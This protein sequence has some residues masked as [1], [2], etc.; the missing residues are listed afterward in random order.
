MAYVYYF[1]KGTLEQK[2]KI[3][4]QHMKEALRN[5]GGIYLK[6]GQLIATIDV[7]VPDQYRDTMMDLTRC[8]PTST[9]SN[10]KK[11]VEGETGKPLKQTFQEFDEKPISS[12]SIAQ[13]HRAR[14]TSGQEV[15]VKV[16]HENLS[17]IVQYDL[18]LMWCFVKVAKF[19]DPS[20]KYQWLIEEF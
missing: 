13:V 4:S 8:C 17:E 18:K 1:H 12:A 20:F 3:A 14:L 2:H 9:F 15:A 10:V 19:L 11:I 16:Q 6:L 7:I 5:S